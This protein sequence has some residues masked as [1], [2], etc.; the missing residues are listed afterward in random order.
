M[1]ES[2]NGGM[3]QRAG[4]PVN[5]SNSPNSPNSSN[6]STPP[7]L[8][9]S[10]SGFLHTSIQTRVLAL[11]GATVFVASGALALLVRPT[12]TAL[13]QELAEQHNRVA[14]IVAARI[15][16]GVDDDLRLLA[17][18]AASS[19]MNGDPIG[20]ALDYVVRNGKPGRCAFFSGN[21][22]M[23]IVSEPLRCLPGLR[24]PAV[25]PVVSRAIETQ[26]P[27]VS[28]ALADADGEA[29]IFYVVP[30][31][32]TNLRPAGALGLAVFVSDR[33]LGE[34]LMSAA[35]GP[36]LTGEL[37][38]G[39][40]RI[41]AMT[42]GRRGTVESTGW[43]VTTI[44]PGTTWSLTLSGLEGDPVASIG[45][46]RR[47][48]LWL[49]P[50]LAAL[51]M[52]FGWGI[53]GSVRRPLKRLTT[54][55][56]RIARG[57]LD[58]RVDA[59]AAMRGGDE[60]DR[61]TVALERMRASLKESMDE[62]GRA[63]RELEARVAER[64]SQLAAVNQTLEE[65][66]L[67]R[68]QLLRKVIS[69]QED[70]RKRIARELHDETSQTL[71]A[72][73]MGVDAA[74]ATGVA[75][76]TTQRLADVR[77]LVDRMHQ[78]LHRMIVNLRPSVLDDL[79]LAAAIQWFAE[80]HLNAAG[81]SVRCELGDLDVRLPA[82]VETALFRA[83]QEA[84]VNVARHAQAETVLIQGAVE[85]GSVT[86]EIEDD[87]VGFEPQQVGSTPGSL[88]GVG[89]LGMRER[90]EILGGSMHLDSEPGGG[91][92]VVMRVPVTVAAQA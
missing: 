72:L 91:T 44:V 43:Q 9:S 52:L 8:H 77:R 79:G 41:L 66:E 48:L 2:R 53:V 13:E 61:L 84:I 58:R 6:S 70:E 62:I 19:N 64:T 49:A 68:E 86:I 18:A 15:A 21:D 3:E 82:E 56:E 40:G 54:A 88:R 85:Q 22:G 14:A 16:S 30:L 50:A 17:A 28:D 29:R 23:P 38:D 75:P 59:G 26:R 39:N 36:S 65:R 83:V 12:L 76:A 55:A 60:I 34:L 51:A 69:A 10:N 78:E 24:R 45:A 71:A 81:V 46:M 37:R 42:A 35:L 87:G 47:R 73:G 7:F 11:V 89:I 63:N 25:A 74:L 1:G 27:I 90:I 5:S 57:D 92:R 67:V 4:R 31:R 33:R 20:L 80:R 32:P